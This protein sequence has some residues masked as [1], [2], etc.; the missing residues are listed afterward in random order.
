MGDLA[1]GWLVGRGRCAHVQSG[2]SREVA[3]GCSPLCM[4]GPCHACLPL[5]VDIHMHIC[6]TQPAS[7]PAT[8]QGIRPPT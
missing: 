6:T 2:C 5:S 4:P 8:H 7:H 1:V 3:A